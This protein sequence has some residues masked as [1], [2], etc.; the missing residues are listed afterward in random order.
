MLVLVPVTTEVW[1]R[2]VL[3]ACRQSAD[4]RTEVVVEH[5]EAGVASIECMVDEAF[6]ALPTLRAVERAV[7]R[8]FDA[9]IIY[10][11]G[12]PGLEAA[13]EQVRIPV[14]GLGEAGHLLA[15]L[16]GDRYGVLSTLPGA[17]PRHWR[18]AQILGTWPKLAAVRPLGLEV[19]SF[20]DHRRV[21]DRALEV[22]REMVE[23]DG[24]HV[25]ALGCG[26]LLGVA[27][28]LGERVGVP[29]VNP[30]VA[31]VKL[32]EAC[33]LMGVSHSPLAYA[34][35]PPKCRTYLA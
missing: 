11:F 35:P 30:A 21:M 31:A 28:E 26:S 17:A 22:C 29:V 15:Y 4:S 34:P 1:D 25:I 7:E 13:R 20:T 33:V 2:P 27:A 16:L 3:E 14:I 18:K 32:A 10:C 24:V 19:L 9:V 5:V 6:A 23:R 8:G 12:N